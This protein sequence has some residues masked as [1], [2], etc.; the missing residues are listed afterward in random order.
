[1]ATPHDN[2]P[3]WL[4]M[5]TAY[6]DESWETVKT[7]FIVAGFLGT[8]NQWIAFASDWRSAVGSDG[9]HTKKLNFES[10][11]TRKKLIKLG[12][13]P[14]KHGLRPLV[15]A[16][17]IV[18][19]AELLANDLERRMMNGYSVALYP[20]VIGCYKAIPPNE[21]VKWVF[22]EQ[23]VYEVTAREVLA[24]MI[25]RVGSERISGVEFLSKGQTSLTQPADFL[26]YATLQGLL[27]PS[28]NKATWSRPIL[29]DGKHIGRIMERDAIRSIMNKM[30]PEIRTKTYE[31][32]KEA[33]DSMDHFTQRMEDLRAEQLKNFFFS[34]KE[35]LRGEQK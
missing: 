20:L 14:H 29:G 4:L 11:R 34:R 27:D 6:L 12:E 35:K 26:A 19:Y 30:L 21:R 5:L 17:K 22:E 24:S 16:V 8:D 25:P 2:P 31:R 13:I 15:G 32:N 18:D 1:M 3:R 7:H 9:F 10:E 23:R 28:S 33:Y